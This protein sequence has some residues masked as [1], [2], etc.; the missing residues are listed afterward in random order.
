MGRL[1]S[2]TSTT[3]LVLMGFVLPI[4]ILAAWAQTTVYDSNAFSQRRGRASS[5]RPPCAMSWPIGSPSSWP[6]TAT[7]TRSRSGPAVVLAIETVVDTDTFRSIFR[8]AIR[9]THEALLQGGNGS[10]GLDL[11]DSFAIVTASLQAPS[12]GKASSSGGLGQSLA[13]V[14]KKLGHLAHLG[15]RRDHQHGR[16]RRRSSERRVGRRWPSRSAVIAGTGWPPLGWVLVID[17]AVHH[18]PA[19]AGPGLRR[20]AVEDDALS[21]A[22]QGA[23]A[24]ATSDLN[25]VAFWMMAYGI[26]VAAAAG[27]LGS[28]ARHLTPAV[29]RSASRD[30]WR[31][32]GR[33][34]GGPSAWP[35]SA[36]W[37]ACCS[38][39]IPR[40]SLALLAVIAGLWLTYL[41]VLELVS[42]IRRGAED[43]AGAHAASG[44]RRTR[45]LLIG[46]GVGVRASSPS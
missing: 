35:C 38:S 6:A 10:T 25:A 31:A 3:L 11:S 23:L 34:P 20:A 29:A 8:T 45:N 15:P 14:T 16:D 42:L 41:S 33:P 28:R 26:V 1:R 36:S 27:A 17:G 7:R 2:V 37:P 44:G 22:V 43:Q 30:G 13:D 21:Q 24:R 39:R 18:R 4:G 46:A 40:G 12:G 19:Q 9:R 32:G 5:T